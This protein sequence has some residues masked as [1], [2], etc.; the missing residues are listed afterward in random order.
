MGLERAFSLIRE[1]PDFPSQGIL[2]QDIAP[3]LA[4]AQAFSDV[5]TAFAKSIPSKTLVAGIEAR[6]FIFA[7]AIALQTGSGFLPIRKA[8]KL[9]GEVHSQ[10]YGL[11]YGS[12]TLEIQKN[13]FQQGQEIVLIDDVLAT[14]GT[15][16]AA[17]TLLQA[18]GAKVSKVMVLLE[19]SILSGREMISSRFPMIEIISLVKR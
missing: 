12:D 4:D 11:E 2:F 5:A 17:I 18:S 9:P 8:G 15:V 6:G 1:V 10:D 19:I 16:V 13:I 7:S 3:M 14:G